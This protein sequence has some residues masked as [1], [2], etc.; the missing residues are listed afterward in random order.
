MLQL[1]SQRDIVAA[2]FPP[3]ESMGCEPHAGVRNPQQ[4]KMGRGAY[5]ALV[6]V[7]QWGFHPTWETPSTPS[8]GRSQPIVP[9][10]A[11]EV[12]P[13]L[14]LLE[15]PRRGLLHIPSS[16]YEGPC[17]LQQAGVGWWGLRRGL[18]LP[19]SSVW[20]VALPPLLRCCICPKAKGYRG[21]GLEIWPCCAWLDR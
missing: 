18:F 16:E 13:D 9:T 14:W 6:S 11:W 4:Q 8:Q 10:P 3:T 12:Y 20:A 5:V 17:L 2:E 15:G 21:A 7:K 19:T 1:G